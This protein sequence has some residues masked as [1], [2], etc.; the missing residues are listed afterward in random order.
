VVETE[1]TSNGIKIY[2]GYNF[3]SMEKNKIEKEACYVA[4][5]DGFY[6]HGDTPRKAIGDLQFKIVAEKLKKEPINKDTKFTVKY[7]RLL[8]GACD[9]GVR[10]WMKA[11]NI[12]FD[13]V[14]SGTSTEETVENKPMTAKE[15]L[16]L[17]EKTNAYG[18]EKVKQLI[19]F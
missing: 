2:S 1:R 15:L 6:A 11:N 18:F 3:L 14:N 8:T 13:V 9:F 4:E 19:T 5:K 17:L 10:S 12:P 7:Y 16:P